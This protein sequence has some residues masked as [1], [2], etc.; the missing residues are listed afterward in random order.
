M[1]NLITPGSARVRSCTLNGEDFTDMVREF[2][3]W[4]S[5]FKPFRVAEA[6]IIDSKNTINR[7][8]LKGNEDFE[9]SFDT[10]NSGTKV[11]K[12][13]FKT[14][15]TGGINDFPSARAQS[16]K[17]RLAD[18]MYYKNQTVRVQQ[19]YSNITG[20][21]MIKKLYETYLKGGGTGKLN[22]LKESKGMIGQ[23]SA[24]FIR[25]NEYPLASISATLKYLFANES[26]NFV[27]YQDDNGDWNV[28]PL[29]YIV[30]QA[31]QNIQGR[32]ERNPTVGKDSKD[33]NSIGNNIFQLYVPEKHSPATDYQN[34]QQV[35]KPT[36]FAGERHD[37]Q[38]A[39]NVEAGK[40]IG[41]ALNKEGDNYQTEFERRV[42]PVMTDKKMMKN[43]P[44]WETADKRQLYASIL[45]NGPRYA[46]TVMG[47]S[48]IDVT[49]GKGVYANIPAP[50][51]DQNPD[52][53][54]DLKGNAV[55][56]NSMKH[57]RLYDANPQF[58]CTFDCFRGGVNKT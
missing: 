3:V 9:I 37:P 17:I 45:Q 57:I 48:G 13:K 30:E 39:K 8:Q 38:K 31:Q 42:T 21:D 54:N 56:A 43:N 51:G 32:F 11:Y 28:G 40:V 16:Y 15:N 1:G 25:A 4:T 41:K 50:M 55:V 49:V 18:E 20:T 19:A 58:T 2:K 35:R 34:T 12:A 27:F 47:D 14:V 26:G 7:L 6:I 10:G 24:K 53:K 5:I 29:E 23:N 36:T 52:T 22:I 44:Y 46:M 33:I